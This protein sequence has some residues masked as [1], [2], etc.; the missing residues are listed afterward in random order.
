M[1]QNPSQPYKI[2]SLENV[3]IRINLSTGATDRM[4]FDANDI[5]FWKPVEEEQNILERQNELLQR[6]LTACHF[7][8]CS[9]GEK[10]QRMVGRFLDEDHEDFSTAYRYIRD[11]YLV[12]QKIQERVESLKNTITEMMEASDTINEL[13]NA[14]L[15]CKDA[16]H[17]CSPEYRQ[18]C[19]AP[20]PLEQQEED[21]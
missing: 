1:I 10:Q 19:P 18:A 20:A 7:L 16:Y 4:A 15:N 8:A 6:K 9:F 5:P 3:T 11:A 2:V 14:A 12:H 17:P 13:G 21:E